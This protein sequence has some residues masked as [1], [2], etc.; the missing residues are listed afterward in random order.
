MLFSQARKYCALPIRNPLMTDGGM[1]K[2]ASL[3]ALSM[4]DTVRQSACR[5]SS[6]ISNAL[7]QA[8]GAVRFVAM[9]MAISTLTTVG[10]ADTF[11]KT[12]IRRCVTSTMVLPSHIAFQAYCVHYD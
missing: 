11:P 3:A 12:N 10:F 4:A 5:G 8:A 1:I 7:T 9:P 2:Q 6:A